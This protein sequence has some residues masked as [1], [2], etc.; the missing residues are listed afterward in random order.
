MQGALMSERL[1]TRR[2]EVG[3]TLIELLVAVALSSL[4][5]VALGFITQSMFQAKRDLEAYETEKDFYRAEYLIRN[6]LA[7][8]VDVANVAAV[9][10]G[11]PRGWL[12]STFSLAPGGGVA[13]VGIFRREIRAFPFPVAGVPGTVPG[14]VAANR[15]STYSNAGIFYFPPRAKVGTAPYRSGVLFLNFGDPNNP[16]AAIRADYNNEIISN[17]VDFRL[18]D[19]VIGPGNMLTSVVVEMVYRQFSA[20]DM[21]K[22]KCFL[23]LN[24]CPDVSTETY[25]DKKRVFQVLLLNAD[26]GQ[27]SMMPPEVRER[28]LGRIYFFRMLSPLSLGGAP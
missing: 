17:L 20:K 8:A 18:R 4:V 15:T 2:G 14:A 26:L 3:M 7:T 16:N 13:P 19:G 25:V 9:P 28:T 27:S 12:L 11:T 21:H 23:P 10:T 6:I 1:V 5:L 24:A 22:E